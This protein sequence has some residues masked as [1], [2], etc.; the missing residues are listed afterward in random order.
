MFHTASVPEQRVQRGAVTQF[1]IDHRVPWEAVIVSLSMLYLAAAVV[2]D[3]RPNGTVIAVVYAIWGVL[4]AEFLIR[5]WDAPSRAGYL[6]RHWVDVV[7]LVPYVSG[8]R[9]LQLL[10]LLR[11]FRV[12]ED[13]DIVAHELHLEHADDK[14][15]R[16]WF[17]APSIV[18]LWLGSACAI[19]IL[20]HGI[21]P[22]IRTFPDAL[23]WSFI[24]GT[25]LGYGANDISPVTEAGRVLAGIVI[26]LAIGFFGYASVLV[27]S[28]WLHEDPDYPDPREEI[29]ELKD[30]VA[31]LR[32]VILERWARESGAVTEQDSR[33]PNDAVG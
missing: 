24:T 22:N 7:S 18:L 23:Y 29:K 31:A 20:E 15:S 1:V 27:T 12:T 11:L 17:L 14:G 8:L 10:R 16:T 19:W 21:N 4:A 30:E 28:L 9:L 26:F 25:T 32:Q 13:E 5:L 3:L 33:T 6:R 2:A